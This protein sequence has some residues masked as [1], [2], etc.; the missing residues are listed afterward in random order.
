MQNMKITNLKAL[1]VMLQASLRGLPL[2]I[3][4]HIEIIPNAFA[5]EL[6]R[7]TAAK[8]GHRYLIIKLKI[9]FR[10]KVPFSWVISS[11]IF[12]TP[13][14]RDTSRQVAMAATGIITEFVRKSK[15]SRNCIPSIWT[16][17]SGPYPRGQCTKQYHDTSNDQC[18]FFSS[19]AELVLECGYGAFG[20]GYG[21]CQRGTQHKQEE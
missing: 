6:I 3:V 19:P 18:R 21:A 20:Q 12:L 8:I 16:L 5:T 13:I 4:C 9:F 15:K 14:T 11:S 7:I 2:N 10:L 1:S 17:P